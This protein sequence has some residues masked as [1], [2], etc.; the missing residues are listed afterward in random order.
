MHPTVL[1]VEDEPSLVAL[2]RYNL[3]KSGYRVEEAVDGQEAMLKVQEEKPDLVLLDWMLPQMS[4][5]EVCRQIRRS[6]EHRRGACCLLHGTDE[7]GRDIHIVCTTAQPRLI[8]ITAYL[9]LPPKW[10]TP[11][12]RRTA[13]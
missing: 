8:I 6:P 11:T 12:Q 5:L 10:I 4:G 13:P 1:I 3:E 7:S 9:P 2:L